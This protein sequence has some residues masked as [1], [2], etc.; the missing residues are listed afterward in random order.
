MMNYEENELGL[1]DPPPALDIPE[2]VRNHIERRL[3]G[4]DIMLVIEKKLTA[5]DMN[6]GENRLSVPRK[7]V[8]VDFLTEEEKQELGNKLK[9]KVGI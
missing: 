7:Q 6:K 3:N 2:E 9:K 1:L 8:R 4:T 5:T